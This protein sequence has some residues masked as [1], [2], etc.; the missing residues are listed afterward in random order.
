MGKEGS[1]RA[2]QQCML[3]KCLM[4]ELIKKERKE[5]GSCCFPSGCMRLIL[6]EPDEEELIEKLYF[7]ESQKE[8]GTVTSG[9]FHGSMLLTKTGQNTGPERLSREVGKRGTGGKGRNTPWRNDQREG[10]GRCLAH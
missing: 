2:P 5:W 1:T 10:A 8:R 6:P 4:N 7:N 9:K 3:I